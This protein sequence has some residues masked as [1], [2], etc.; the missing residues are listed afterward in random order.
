MSEH[1]GLRC[2][3]FLNETVATEPTDGGNPL[4]PRNGARYPR[5]SET[6]RQGP[7]VRR[8]ARVLGG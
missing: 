8:Q 3:G 5:R 2:C 6:R 7:A 1:S 4:P